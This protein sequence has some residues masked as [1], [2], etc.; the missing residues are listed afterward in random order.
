MVITR[1]D[2]M[3]PAL[4]EA[5]GGFINNLALR[6]IEL[7]LEFQTTKVKHDFYRYMS[8]EQEEFNCWMNSLDSELGDN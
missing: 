7:D 4:A 8:Y 6:G 1:V 3:F 2:E 5:C